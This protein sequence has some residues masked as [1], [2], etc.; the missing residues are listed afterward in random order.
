[1]SRPSGPNNTGDE[2]VIDLCYSY[3]PCNTVILELSGQEICHGSY[4]RQPIQ[5]CGLVSIQS[6]IR[7]P[8]SNKGP[9][10]PSVPAERGLRE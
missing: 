9:C 3:R 6:T 1:M 10:S 8:G 7:D 5:T 2:R 4:P